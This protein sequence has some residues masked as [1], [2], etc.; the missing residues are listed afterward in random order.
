MPAVLGS[1]G[2]CSSWARWCRP[3]W[4]RGLGGCPSACWSWPTAA[5]TY[6]DLSKGVLCCRTVEDVLTPLED[7]FMLDFGVLASIMQSGHTRI[8]VYEAERSNV[9]DML[10]L[11][12]L[13][14]VDPE[15]CTPL[16]TITCF[17]NHPLHFLFKDPKLDAVLEEFK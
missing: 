3:P 11:K 6:S 9:V 8:P 12:D 5:A 1:V 15:D 17:Y 7:C 4:R 13:A 10:Y 2:S 14:F 16:S